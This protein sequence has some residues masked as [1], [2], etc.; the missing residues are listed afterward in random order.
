VRFT[1]YLDLQIKR[2]TTVKNTKINKYKKLLR[3]TKQK[4]QA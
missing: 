2:S 3:K 1:N 4:I